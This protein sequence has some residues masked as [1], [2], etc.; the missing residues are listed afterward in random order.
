MTV[1]LPKVSVVIPVFNMHE[2]VVRAVRSVGAQSE[3][4]VDLIIVDDG[5]SDDSGDRAVEAAS[6]LNLSCQLLTSSQNEGL[7]EAVRRGLA[8]ARGTFAA[9]LPADDI[10]F[11]DHLRLSVV[12]VERY[13]ECVSVAG[14]RWTDSAGRTVESSSTAAASKLVESGGTVSVGRVQAA[15]DDISGFRL[16]QVVARTEVLRDAKWTRRTIEGETEHLELEAWISIANGGYSFRSTGHVS[17]QWTD[18]PAQRHKI[19]TGRRTTRMNVNGPTS[20]YSSFRQFY[21][22]PGSVRFAWRPVE[23]GP[24]EPLGKTQAFVGQG[25]TQARA[26]SRRKTRMLLVG[27]AGYNPERL[28][29]LEEY[30]DVRTCWM[31]NPRPWDY[32]HDERGVIDG[33]TSG[34]STGSLKCPEVVYGMLNWQALEHLVQ[35]RRTFP[36]TPFILH[37]KE[38]PH[39]ATQHGLMSL[40]VWLLERADGAIF[41]NE[42][43]RSYCNL[44]TFRV[45]DDTNSEVFD[46]DAPDGRWSNAS[47]DGVR[48]MPRTVSVGRTN[49]DQILNILPDRFGLDVYGVDPRT[50]SS[51]VHNQVNSGRV[52]I[53]GKINPEM[54]ATELPPYLGGWLHTG[55]CVTGGEPLA[56][57]W[58]DLNI[59]SR[60][61][62][63]LSA[64]IPSIVDHRMG[65]Y[66]ALGRLIEAKRLGWLVN[67]AEELF[68]Y[69]TEELHSS[70]M[71][72]SVIAIRDSLFFDAF[73]PRL[74]D[75]VAQVLAHGV[76]KGCPTDG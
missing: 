5:S 21:E 4:D 15:A 12:T 51:T 35:V 14:C 63:Y 22:I 3:V 17:T 2:F 26:S 31:P 1:T 6:E 18:H 24:E 8:A 60:L 64:A 52:R 71:S 69:L 9:V 76:V 27:S 39:H 47:V 7:G 46:G 25:M 13:P 38:S 32:A 30:F 65:G 11:S 37:F 58:D 16:V 44:H 20:G 19:L 67:S 50:V 45:W 43:S 33:S 75:Y 28:S 70:A 54:W 49:I 73:V 34:I 10:M 68:G 29:G 42:E 23:T 74:S 61:G 40:L 36:R 72:S 57:T 56:Y 66:T 53:K 55:S 59:P 48:K 62:T 41:L